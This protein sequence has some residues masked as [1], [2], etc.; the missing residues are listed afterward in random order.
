MNGALAVDF[1]HAIMLRD[2]AEPPATPQ[3]F[4]LQL[5]NKFSDP[6]ND[7]HLVTI[8][9][10]MIFNDIVLKGQ[11]MIP[12]FMERAI[13]VKTTL[14]IGVSLKVMGK[15]EKFYVKS[16][17]EVLPACWRARVEG[18][19]EVDEVV[20]K[21]ERVELVEDSLPEYKEKEDGKGEVK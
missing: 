13:A 3:E 14:I 1:E 5:L 21:I 4:S 16:E 11:T 17:V 8:D 20:N 19:D 9:K 15:L 7:G 6:S 2:C 10:D 12:T 18:E